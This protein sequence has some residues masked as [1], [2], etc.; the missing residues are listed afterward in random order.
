MKIIYD[1]V[2]KSESLRLDE[3]PKLRENQISAKRIPKLIQEEE[4]RNE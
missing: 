1:K 2:N 4:E 3:S